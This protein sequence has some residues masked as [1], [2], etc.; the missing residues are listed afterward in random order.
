[1]LRS[2]IKIAWRNLLRQRVFSLINV[3][4]LAMGMTAFFF[5][6]QYTNFHNS[7]DTFHLDHNRMYRIGQTWF[8]NGEIEIDGVTNWYASGLAFEKNIPEVESYVRLREW[9]GRSAV[10]YDGTS[11]PQDNIFFADRSFFHFFDYKWLK[12]DINTAFDQLNDV[13]ISLQTATKYFGDEDPIG[14]SILLK[15]GGYNEEHLVKGVIHIPEN[16]WLQPEV[17]LNYERFGDYG[18]SNWVWSDVYLFL[19][20]QPGINPEDLSNK[21]NKTMEPHADIWRSEGYEVAMTFD[22]MDQLHT[23]TKPSKISSY[24]DPDTL[25]ILTLA[26]LAVLAMAWINSIQLNTSQALSRAKEVGIRRTMGS[27]VVTFFLQFLVE[28]LFLNFIAFSLSYTLFQSFSPLLYPLLELDVIPFQYGAVIRQGLV[29][30]IVG[31]LITGLYPTIVFGFQ[32][33]GDVLKRKTLNVG[34]GISGFRNTMLILQ[35]TLS[36]TLISGAAF[37]FFHLKDIQKRDIG[38]DISQLMVINTPI[39][40]DSVFNQRLETFKKRLNQ[41][42]DILHVS[43]TSD[44][45]GKRVASNHTSLRKVGASPDQINSNWVMRAD[46]AFLETYGLELLTGRGFVEQDIRHGKSLMLNESAV[47]NLGF[48]SP[49]DAL[50]SDLLWD[51]INEPEGYKVVGVIKDYHHTSFKN[52]I[53]PTIY[54]PLT[55]WKNYIT[56]KLNS[57]DLAGSITTL[58][59]IYVETFDDDL[60]DYTLLSDY[61]YK[62]YDQDRQLGELISMFGFISLGIVSFCLVGYAGMVLHKRKKEISV[63][64]VFGASISSLFVLLSGRFVRYILT[65]YVLATLLVYW[66]GSEWLSQYLVDININQLVLLSPLVM[67]FLIAGL[68]IMSKMAQTIQVNPITILKEQN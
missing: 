39:V 49:E 45:P 18:N 23:I 53:N 64:K 14:K 68:S 25:S 50:G 59:R 38:Y 21:F 26:A 3:L 40:K 51:G 27:G 60:F 19:K 54:V 2:Y 63:R 9:V 15:Q 36:C 20:F 16:S 13:V 46:E 55:R 37:I 62:Q 6:T 41:E 17:L 12:G 57:E 44:V 22:R 33:P 24:V 47:Y 61:Y 4:G 1:M 28:S 56:V 67:M 35:L 34:K 7:F 29:I 66:Y 58:S 43:F 5:I 32:N 65:S 42:S 8:K 31:S 11:L 10:E 52:K 48:K 30:V